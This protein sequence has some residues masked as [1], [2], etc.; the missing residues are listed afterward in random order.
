MSYLKKNKIFIFL[1][2]F[3]VYVFYIYNREEQIDVNTL[4]L[5][6]DLK[7]DIKE[8]GNPQALHGD[9]LCE[10]DGDFPTSSMVD[11]THIQKTHNKNKNLTKEEQYWYYRK[12]LS[13]IMLCTTS[14]GLSI[15]QMMRLD[16][17]S[18]ILEKKIKKKLPE[19][20]FVTA[21]NIAV[22]TSSPY[23]ILEKTYLS[24]NIPIEKNVDAF[25]SL[26]NN[27]E[28]LKQI[29]NLKYQND[30][31]KKFDIHIC[32]KKVIDI[33]KIKTTDLFTFMRKNSNELSDKFFITELDNWRKINKEM[34][35]ALESSVLEEFPKIIELIDINEKLNRY[36]VGFQRWD[37]SY[38]KLVYVEHNSNKYLCIVEEMP[39]FN[40]GYDI[41]VEGRKRKYNFLSFVT[42]QTKDIAVE[43]NKERMKDIKI[44]TILSYSI[45]DFPN[46]EYENLKPYVI[47]QKK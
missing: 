35:N 44:S 27:F 20:V 23:T 2:V 45:N 24:A 17:T 4:L 33:Y 16:N 36:V 6:D 38:Q 31:N 15:L 47:S 25:F 10:R 39:K 34:K 46:P 28:I 26:K 40:N 9:T 13:N 14:K 5:V 8:S 43:I 29:H 42:E 22:F 12:S 30:E 32:L 37:Y 7:K 41:R 19:D 3:I 11:N 21:F 1:L 18:K